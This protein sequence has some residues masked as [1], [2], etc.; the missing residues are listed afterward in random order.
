M[1]AIFG[2]PSITAILLGLI[3]TAIGVVE[4]LG[5]GQLRRLDLRAVRILTINQ[6]CLATLILL[7]ALWNLH[8]EIAHPD[9]DLAGL[10]PSD[11]QTLVQGDSSVLG[12]THEIMVLLYGS[13]IAAA[14][15][16]AAM[17]GYYHTRGAYL[18]QYL[19]QTPPWIV[20]MQKAG[21]S[22]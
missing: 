11:A 4:I 12:I 17:A 21:V 7:Y 18:R 8:G 22:I 9:S 16:E 14:V 3:L 15:F 13:L 1:G 19:A 6:L 5:G 2:I 10:S 20:A